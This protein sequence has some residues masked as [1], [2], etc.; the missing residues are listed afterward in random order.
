[1]TIGLF[2]LN[3]Q[4]SLVRE[5]VTP[6]CRD[7]FGGWS[8][9]EPIGDGTL[10]PAGTTQL[11]GSGVRHLVTWAFPNPVMNKRAGELPNTL[12]RF[13]NVFL[14][15]SWSLSLYK[16][17][18]LENAPPSHMRFSCRTRDV[19]SGVRARFNKTSKATKSRE[20]EGYSGGFHVSFCSC[21]PDW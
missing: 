6:F 4:I 7:G 3:T 11:F 18:S 19:G 2:T 14:T 8:Y 10:S 21:L 20:N 12:D 1:M 5:N 15:T 9:H 13:F 16:K 17:T